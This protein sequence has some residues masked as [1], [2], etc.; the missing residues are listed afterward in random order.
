MKTCPVEAELF[1]AGGWRD[2]Q[3]DK[4]TGMMKLIVA[5]RNFTNVRKMVPVIIAATGTM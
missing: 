4:E 5:F 3:A 1:R 2:G